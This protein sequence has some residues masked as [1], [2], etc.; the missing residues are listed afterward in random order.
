MVASLL[1]V[2]RRAAHFV[3]APFIWP[4]QKLRDQVNAFPV[5]AVAILVALLLCAVKALR[6]DRLA[7]VGLAA[8][9]LMWVLFNGPLEGP[10]LLVLSW[11]HGL[12][13]ADLISVV[14]LMIAAWRLAPAL[15][16][17]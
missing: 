4:L 9:S 3:L 14:G 7:A 6:G 11:S 10:T 8:L 12:T 13:A 17:R 5:L 2:V 15:I 1:S 16:G